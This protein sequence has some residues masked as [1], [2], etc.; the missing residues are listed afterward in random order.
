MAMFRHQGLKYLMLIRNGRAKRLR[1]LLREQQIIPDTMGRWMARLWQQ[2]IAERL[3]HAARAATAP[4]RH[5]NL[6]T[7]CFLEL[8]NRMTRCQDFQMRRLSVPAL[9]R[10]QNCPRSTPWR[11]AYA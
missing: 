1:R 8:A 5:C 10:L 7:D 9:A 2:Q 11:T 6:K 4:S 3:R